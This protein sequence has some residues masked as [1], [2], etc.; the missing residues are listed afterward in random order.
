MLKTLQRRV[1]QYDRT[2]Q[3][4][5]V[6]ARR[7]V[8]MLPTR[9]GV[10]FALVLLLMLAGSINYALSLGFILTF[11]LAGLGIT[12]I[13]HTYRNLAGLRITAARTSAV[14][15][16]EVAQFRVRIE[17]RS[18]TDRYSLA[19]TRNKRDV[20]RVDAPA[21][22]AVIAVAPV[23][24]VRRGVLRPGRFTLFTRFPIGLFHAWSYVELDTECLVYPRPATPGLPLPHDVSHFP[25][26]SRAGRGT[27]DF[28]GLRDYQPGD[29]PRHIAWKAAAR[30]QALLTKQ[31]IGGASGELRFSLAQ[32]PADLGL[33]EKLS[34]LTRWVL[35]ANRAGLAYALELPGTLLP[36]SSGAAH[37]ERCLEALARFEP[38]PHSA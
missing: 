4:E 12:G 32:L 24:T 10:V 19:L 22:C 5:A 30:G 2:A 20:T 38:P 8:F 28:S 17:N 37:R 26:G 16:G 7:R 23:G 33:E 13:L 31:F 27:Q 25:E 6:L 21:A 3:R 35:D 18:G 34:C 11:L 14:F 36:L 1:F 9:A 29:A 15:A